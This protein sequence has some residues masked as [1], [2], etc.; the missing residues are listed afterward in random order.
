MKRLLSAMAML[1]ASSAIVLAN[2]NI[3][4]M[5]NTSR[6]MDNRSSPEL[7]VSSLYN[8]INLRQ[9]SRAY[10]YLR[11]PTVDLN[12]YINGF[13]NTANDELLIGEVD[14]I[15]AES[16]RLFFG[17]PIKLQ[18]TDIDGNEQYYSGCY[19]IA[20]AMTNRDANF[21]FI[22][23]GVES[24]DIHKSSPDY[25]YGDLFTTCRAK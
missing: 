11:H 2:P 22:P 1:L 18:A 25:Y 13:M 9:Y 16:G 8:A 5:N 12:E 19:L 3:E 6:Y 24:A 15:R 17:V 20:P 14:V 23:M 7:L 4:Y 21:P 10:S